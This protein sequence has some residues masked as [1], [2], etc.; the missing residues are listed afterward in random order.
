[1]QSLNTIWAFHDDKPGHLSQVQGLCAALKRLH[2]LDI[3]FIN[4]HENRSTCHLPAPQLV[5]GAGHRTHRKLLRAARE[6]R[7]FSAVLM[8]PSLP[9]RLFNAIICPQ[10]D[11]LKASSR[12][13]NTLGAITKV[14]S[15]APK[16]KHCNNQGVIAFGGPSKHYQWDPQALLQQLAHISQHSNIDWQVFDS[17]RSPAGFSEALAA[18]C[19]AQQLRFTSFQDCDSETLAQ[20]LANAGQAW[21]SPDSVSMVYEALSAGCATGIFKLPPSNKRSK[22]RRG[23]TF[24]QQQAWLTELDWPTDLASQQALTLSPPPAQLDEATRAA[25]W[26]LQRLE[27]WHGQSKT[28]Q[29]LS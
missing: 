22:V 10:H 19:Q 8:K 14:T 29:G 7:A 28:K 25:K 2:T 13:L 3:H 21:L 12:V 11:G 16:T 6:H 9:K 23:I 15:Q 24:L 17:P 4:V 1:M 5:L 18:M 20:A 27:S 26:L